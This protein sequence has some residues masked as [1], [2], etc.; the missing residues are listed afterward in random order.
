MIKT[1]EH[2]RQS[3][4]EARV[5][6]KDLIYPL[7]VIAGK[8]RKEDVSSMPGVSRFSSDL[9]IEQIRELK[10]LGLEK[11]LLFGVPDS[12]DW[13]GVEAY[14]KDNLVV[15]AIKAI[16]AEFSTITLM[17]DV[18]LCAYTKHGHCGLIDKGHEEING[19][20]TLKALSNMALSH[21]QAGADYV[22]PSAMADGQ[23]KAIRNKLDENGFK[24]VRIMGYSAKFASNFYGPFRS[25]ADSA[26]A[27]GDRRGYQ[28]DY[29]RI[30]PALHKV[31]EDVQGGADIVMVKPALGY[32]D[33]IRKVKDS[34]SKPLAVYNVSG[35]YSFVKQ[36][37]DVN[38]WK[39]KDMVYEILSSFKRAG[40]DLII[41]YH[42]KDIARWQN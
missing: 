25:I 31:E 15:Q 17:T 3:P 16:R 10:N 21:A 33:V 14:G 35:E 32:L 8:G 37:A 38:L 22:A 4:V 39:E 36:G 24:H 9:L 20:L 26:P 42:A 1:I 30:Q 18:C 13:D 29:N 34:F 12:K 40:A 7:F 28:L 6:L 27:F 2:E 11:F 41:T 19:E 5:D 23:V